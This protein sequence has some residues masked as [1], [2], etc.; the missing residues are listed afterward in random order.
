MEHDPDEQP[1]WVR[2]PGYPQQDPLPA[3]RAGGVRQ[4]RRA[5]N[6][7]AALLVAGV[8]AA[9]GYFAHHL[10]PAGS[11]AGTATHAQ[12]AGQVAAAGHG[13]ASVPRQTSGSAPLVTSGGSGVAVGTATGAGRTAGRSATVTWRDN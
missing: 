2:L 3:R 7:T 6:W 10:P 13:A 1:G 9:T 8:A 11:T 12:P 4:V 5:S